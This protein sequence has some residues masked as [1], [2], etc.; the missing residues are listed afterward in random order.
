MPS[1]LCEE[2]LWSLPS[3]KRAMGFLDG[4]V[5]VVDLAPGSAGLGRNGR[6]ALQALCT[7]GGRVRSSFTQGG[8]FLD[9][10]IRRKR[11]LAAF[12]EDAKEAN[13]HEDRDA[14]EDHDEDNSR[15][16]TEDVEDDSDMGSSEMPTD[17]AKETP[18]EAP[19][20][21]SEDVK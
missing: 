3:Q 6:G 7:P 10:P 21:S 11:L 18:Q 17:V 8:D 4:K 2:A 15:E 19:G 16:K 1:L 20:K 13:E 9:V 14:K 5:G 12:G